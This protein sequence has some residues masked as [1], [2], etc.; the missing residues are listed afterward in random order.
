MNTLDRTEKIDAYLS[1]QMPSE[2]R[3][4]FERLLSA[5]AKSL[6]SE[7]L[8]DE[9]K[10]QKEIIRAIR[11]RGLREQLQEQE[12][13]MR[14]NRAKKQRI[15][16]LSG[17]SVGTFSMVAVLCIAFVLVPLAQTMVR[18]STEY[19]QSITLSPARGGTSDSPQTQLEQVYSLVAQEHWSEA[20]TLSQSLMETT[21]TAQNDLTP[22]ECQE[23]YE[24]A[25]W[26]Y[27]MCEMHQKHIFRAKRLL[28]QIAADGGRYANQAQAMLNAL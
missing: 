22:E 24:Q 11:E 28:R 15:I 2:E 25:Q 14:A 3:K 20:S 4:E 8:S 10:M 9:M 26:L 16:R 6:D 13:Q 17:W 27:T 7:P 18:L 21:A 5:D 12:K 23:I 19:A 1:G